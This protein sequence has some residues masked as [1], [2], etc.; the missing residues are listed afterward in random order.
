VDDLP[1]LEV[2]FGQCAADLSPQLDAI[3]GRELAEETSP[4]I[5]LALQGLADRHDR[6]GRRR[7]RGL[8]SAVGHK[9]EPGEEEAKRCRGANGHRPPSPPARPRHRFVQPFSFKCRRV[10]DLI[11]E[12]VHKSLPY[13]PEF[14]CAGA[15]TARASY[16]DMSRG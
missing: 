6:G 7:R 15:G 14:G 4:D 13:R 11:H 3:D 5:D 16:S 12:T 10:A 1:V 8:V 2:D 9:A